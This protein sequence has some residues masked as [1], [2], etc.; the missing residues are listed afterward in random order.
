MIPQVLRTGSSRGRIIRNLI[1]LI[2][3]RIR[4]WHKAVVAW[5]DA[6]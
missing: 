5:I 4:H 3:D 1:T 6:V 2:Q